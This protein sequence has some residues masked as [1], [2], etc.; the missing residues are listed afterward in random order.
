VKGASGKGRFLSQALPVCDSTA[1]CA[2][3]NLAFVANSETWLTP[4]A[5]SLSCSLRP[6]NHPPTT[7]EPLA[8]H[9]N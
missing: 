4:G 9:L 2:W 7:P 1:G 8:P 5:A 3:G 6:I